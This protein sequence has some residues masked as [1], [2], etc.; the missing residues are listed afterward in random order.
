L[1]QT[2]IFKPIPRI[3]DAFYPPYFLPPALINQAEVNARMDA[4]LD[5]FA[6]GIPPNFSAICWPGATP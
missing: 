3:I 2:V 6:L 4:G 1:G 5:T